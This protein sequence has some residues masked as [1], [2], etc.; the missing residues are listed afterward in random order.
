MRLTATGLRCV[1]G[2]RE[3]FDGLDFMAEA[4][5]ALAVVGA[6][7]A[8]KT[9]LLRLIAGLIAPAGGTLA[10]DGGGA[11]LSVA[12]RAHYLGHRDALKSALSVTENLA[13][14]RAAL[15]GATANLDTAL[16]AVGLDHIADLP[17]AYLSAGQRRRL[18][19]AR[20]L[21]VR[22]PLWLLD[23]PTS[24]LDAGGQAMMADLMRDHLGGGGIIV[25][26][27]HLPLGIAARQLRIGERVS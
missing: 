7:G 5:E 2:G 13:F 17:A 16:K 15:G 24:S 20:L 4:G 18:S 14:W 6:N 1:R 26:A 27:T 12:E 9:S 3:I 8:G 25:A 19:I 10:L 22:R 23:E 21:A 11:D